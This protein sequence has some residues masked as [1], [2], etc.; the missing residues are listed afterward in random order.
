MSKTP[1]RCGGTDFLDRKLNPKQ[2]QINVFEMA[3]KFVFDVVTMD[4]G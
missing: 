1:F 2:K 4:G 3:A